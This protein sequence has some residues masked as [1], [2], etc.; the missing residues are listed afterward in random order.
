MI[1]LQHEAN[2]VVISVVDD[3][4]SILDSTRQLLRSAGYKV[5]TF[6][7]AREFLESGSIKKSECLILDVK[8]PGIDGLELQR[9][10]T[11]SGAGVPIS[12]ISA[13]D[14]GSIRR[15][16][17]QAGAVDF[18]NKPFETSALLA[19]IATAIRLA[20]TQ[21]AAHI[22][23][24][25]TNDLHRVMILR[26]AGYVVQECSSA[27]DLVELC[28][29]GTPPDLICVSEGLEMP[30]F[31]ALVIA[32]TKFVIPV[33]FFRSSTRLFPDFRFDREIEQ[34]TS[35]AQWLSD[36]HGALTESRS[37]RQSSRAVI[38]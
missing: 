17:I 14:D 30:P 18:L 38:Q 19:T 22:I 24:F 32:R 20:T 8:M 31:E 2:G 13:H 1:D 34:L 4:E 21:V 36:I 3:D 26:G 29:S 35:P 9:R 25:G 28:E 15:Q 10:L 23:H 5:S 11:D 6:V 37:A 7:S 16:A 33:V 12:F 27:R